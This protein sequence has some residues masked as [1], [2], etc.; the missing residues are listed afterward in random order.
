[1][2]SYDYYISALDLQPRP[3]LQLFEDNICYEA[4]QKKYLYYLK[5]MPNYYLSIVSA[6]AVA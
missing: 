4:V 5:M 2:Q 3:P 6:S 1:M